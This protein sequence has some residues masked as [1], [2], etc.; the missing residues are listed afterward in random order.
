MKRKAIIILATAA[1][2]AAGTVMLL[3]GCSQGI[4]AEEVFNAFAGTD[5]VTPVLVGA[6]TQSSSV[7]RL[8][9]SEPVKV[10]GSS[11]GE[12]SA[13]SDGKSIYITLPSSLEPGCRSEIS[14]RV[15]DYAGNT[16]GFSV[17]VWGL[18]P[19]MPE[20]LINE[21]TTKG[22]EKSPDRTEL[23]IMSD[24]NLNGMVLYS[25]IPDDWDVRV[26]FPDMEVR[27]GDKV[28]VWWTQELPTSAETDPSCL[29]ICASSSDGLPSNNGTLVLCD[30]PSL[31]AGVLDAVVYSNFSPS[32]Q[33]YGTKSAEQR[34]MWVIGSGHW[35]GDALDST[36]STATRSMSRNMEGKDSDSSGDWYI[37][38]TGGY[39]FGSD[40]TSES[41]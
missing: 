20:V 24:G 34:A 28:V 35:K 32:H 36:S 2:L 12:Y 14:G 37:T 38:V 29:N 21:F 10:Y 8:D 31:G 3:I 17:Q 41:Y 30:T 33:G 19:R 39:T 7:V 16:C 5:N 1:A 26:V 40:N 9:F 4:D 6:S 11:L 13:R 18:N 22:T 15:R 23:R 25:G 27:M